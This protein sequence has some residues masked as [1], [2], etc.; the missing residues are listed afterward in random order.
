MKLNT[1][2]VNVPKCSTPPVKAVCNTLG[3]L[4]INSTK[5]KSMSS[6]TSLGYFHASGAI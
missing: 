4:P 1:L 6:G 2:V 3:V 5:A